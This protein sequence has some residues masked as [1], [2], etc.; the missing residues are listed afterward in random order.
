MKLTIDRMKISNFKGI[1][2]AEF[3]FSDETNIYGRNASGKSSILDAF[4]WLLFN[5]SANGD[6]PGS[7]NFREKPLDA[8]GHEIHYLDTTVELFCKLDGKPFN[9]RRTQRENWVTK[10]GSKDAVFQGNGSTYWINEVETKV[11]DFN[12]QIRG[13]ANDDVFRL[14]TTLGAFNAMEWRKRRAILISMCGIDVDSE[15]LRKDDY[16][17]LARECEVLGVGPDDLKKVLGDRKKML[18][19][20]LQLIPARIDEANKLRPQYTEQ[21]IKDAEYLVKTSQNDLQSCQSLLAQID[22]GTESSADL[23]R[24]IL[25]LETE[26]VNEKRRIADEFDAENRKFRTAVHETE[27]A[28]EQIARNQGVLARGAADAQVRLNEAAKQ[29]TALRDEYKAVYVE[30]FVEPNVD[31]VCPT[32]GQPIPQEQITATIEKAK[33]DF[34]TRK[35][36]RLKDISAKGKQA[37]ASE[38]EYREAFEKADG[39]LKKIDGEYA[40]AKEQHELAVA[41]YQKY[42]VE[43]NYNTERVETL[44]SQIY[45]L[46]E[47]KNAAPDTKQKAVMDRISELEEIIRRNQAVVAM[48]DAA[49]KVDERIAELERQQEEM[50]ARKAE[51]E[52]L[53]FK[54]EQFTA[55]RCSLLEDSIN[56]HFPTIR[57]KLFD[58]QINGALVDCCECMIPGENALVSYNGTNTAASVNADIEIIGV[59]SKH[60]DLIAPVFVDNAERINYLVKPA[61]QLITMSVSDDPALRIEHKREA[62]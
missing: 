27:M 13:I 53:I 15:L 24:Q 48:Q 59:L 55:E 41:T 39:E 31:G 16:L 8:D 29:V 45:A 20:E 32:C 23:Q 11:S 36:Q 47:Q 60:Y 2:E 18:Q 57:W 42:P 1:R 49:K 21:D 17:D 19:K 58:R 12:A 26:M 51:V 7:D 35:E 54:V 33:A 3:E 43:P 10:R 56:E 9:L 5:K 37:A 44:Q 6:A 40:K 30:P 34:I 62:A 4:C 22:A 52:L 14:I 61:G 50:G 25:A 46:R 38:K 28:M